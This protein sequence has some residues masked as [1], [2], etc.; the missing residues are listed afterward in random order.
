MSSFALGV[1]VLNLVELVGP[2]R[3]ISALATPSPLPN[4][5]IHIPPIADSKCSA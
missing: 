1:V 2:D 4:L 5:C 3:L